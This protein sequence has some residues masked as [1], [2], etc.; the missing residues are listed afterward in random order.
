MAESA[1]RHDPESRIALPINEALGR[2]SETESLR[3]RLISRKAFL[4]CAEGSFTPVYWK[5]VR[6]TQSLL[7]T[8]LN[9]KA[10]LG[11]FSSVLRI[12]LLRS[13]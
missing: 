9:D 1:K 5:P 4:F 7:S 13:P 11:N 6:S 12:D 3:I 2:T 10:D 8:S